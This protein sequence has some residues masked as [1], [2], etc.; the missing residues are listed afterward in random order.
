MSGTKQAT[1]TTHRGKR[2]LF[3]QSFRCTIR[4]SR[5]RE[6]RRE[7][8]SIKSMF[9]PLSQIQI[10]SCLQH[11][12]KQ[13]SQPLARHHS[14]T[15]ELLIFA[16]WNVESL[17]RSGILFELKQFM[18]LRKIQILFLSETKCSENTYFSE[19]FCIF[20]SGGTSRDEKHGVG[21]IIH[22]D[23]LP[24]LL[25]VRAISPEIILLQ[26]KITGGHLTLFGVYTTDMTLTCDKIFSINYMRCT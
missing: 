26:L 23:L 24:N 18:R 21:I 12:N 22:R 20:L 19:E 9:R 5:R 6:R 16:Y 17:K 3:A 25:A 2:S 14:M 10:S 4:R 7:Y 8:R 1:A 15:G 11:E 13:F